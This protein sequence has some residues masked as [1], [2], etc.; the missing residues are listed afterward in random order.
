[1]S[2]FHRHYFNDLADN[3]AKKNKN[4][5]FLLYAMQE[6]GVRNHDCVLDVGSGTGC[7]TK[8]LA[9]LI[10]PPGKVYALD[11]SEKMLFEAKRK[12]TASSLFICSDI[13]RSAFSKEY[14]DKIICYSSFP[15]IRNQKRAL[16]EIE[17]ILKPKGKLL[18]YH[19]CCSR[20]LNHY[21]AQLTNVVCFDK[22]PK[23]EYLEKMINAAGMECTK[24]VEK[25]D[26]YW[27]EAQKH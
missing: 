17:R 24:L 5:D 6:F 12:L 25:S 13:S 7:L 18:I 4:N 15:H 1:M 19:T 3:W 16:E 2:Q 20:K 10:E 26:L 11:I 9:Q 21:H 8:I 22:L 27:V 14:F 23:S